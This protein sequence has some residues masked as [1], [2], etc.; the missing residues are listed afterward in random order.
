VGIQRLSIR[1]FLEQS[2]NHLLLDVRSPS[3][4]NHAHIPGAYSFPLFTDEERKVVGTTYKQQGRKQAIKTGLDYFSPKMKRMVEEIETKIDEGKETADEG[5]RQRS[6]TVFI[7]CWR[8]GMRS[9]A[10]AWLLDLYGFRVF[11]LTGGYKAFRNEVLHTFQEPYFFRILGGYTG[12]GKTEVL[13]Q[14]EKN[15]EQIIDLET[16]ACHRGSAFGSFNM[17]PQ[18]TQEMFENLLAK[19]LR[20]KAISN[21]DGEPV[22]SNSIPHSVIWLEDESQ[23]IGNLNIPNGIWQQMRQSS[24]IF[25]EIPFNQRLEYIV[26]LYGLC[27]K[28]KLLEAV[29]R[30]AKRLGPLE[31]RN[32]IEFLQQDNKKEAFAILLH[33][34]DKLY[35]KAL[36]NRQNLPDLLTRVGCQTVNEQNANLISK[37]HS[38]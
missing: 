36:H 26:N 22:S 7:Y 25:L 15:G 31:T 29:H 2:A 1:N 10:I 30:I 38:V 12:S 20:G 32:T 18:P 24:I 6:G 11:V 33:Y 28:E 21:P 16:I 3:E 35:L 37:H 23:R 5:S 34:Y 13:Q 4:F 19:Q 14:L 9:A 27:D 8:G 17:P